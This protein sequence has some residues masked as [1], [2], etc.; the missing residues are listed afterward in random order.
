[1]GADVSTSE[2]HFIILSKKQRKSVEDSFHNFDKDSDGKLSQDDFKA[3]VWKT[4]PELKQFSLVL[5]AVFSSDQFYVSFS[6]FSRFYDALLLVKI[7]DFNPN[8]LLMIVFKYLDKDSNG[9][10]N[11]KEIKVLGNL[12]NQLK[13]GKPK[14]HEKDAKNFILSRKPEN[15]KKGLSRAEFVKLFFDFHPI[16][17]LRSRS[18]KAGPV[19]RQ[20]SNSFP[21]K[22]PRS[23]LKF[24]YTNKLKN[25]DRLMAEFSDVERDQNDALSINEVKMLLQNQSILPKNYAS[26]VLK[27]FGDEGFLTFDGYSA[28]SD[29]LSL[30]KDDRESFSKKVFNL[31]DSDRDG[32]LTLKDCIKYGK[33]LN[34]S[35]Q[36]NSHDFWKDRLNEC[37][38][39]HG[40][41]GICFP[42]FYEMMYLLQ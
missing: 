21:R 6:D 16:E 11:Y 33:D 5:F 19:K 37:Q 26:I 10:L 1:M 20:R 4:F 40:K 9:F 14:Y 32:I 42:Y 39:I 27:L 12:I 17:I 8:S 25:R 7:D 36:S 34:L 18:I 2:K 38:L 31:Y 29:S 15:V 13:Q 28:L 3:F 30:L 35:P 23:S 41:N 22:S 24:K